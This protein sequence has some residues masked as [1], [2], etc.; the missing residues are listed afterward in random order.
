VRHTRDG[1]QEKP[2]AIL[3]WLNINIHGWGNALGKINIAYPL[4]VANMVAV[5]PKVR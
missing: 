2:K 5:T 3:Q 4:T 1:S